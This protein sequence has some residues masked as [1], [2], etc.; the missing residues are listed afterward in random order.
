MNRLKKIF[1]T[2]KGKIAFYPSLIS[3][4]GILLA[5][6]MI[7]L[8]QKQISAYLMKVAPSLVI[9]NLDTAQILLSTLISGLISLVVFSF[10]MV[11]VLLN[12]AS[13]NFSPR[14]LPGIIS[15]QK[16]QVVLGIYIATILYMIFILVSIEP[17]GSSYQTPGFAVLI[18]IIL[19]VVCLGSFIYFIHHISQSIQVGNILT[20]IH[21]RTKN[22]IL[23]TIKEQNAVSADFNG[24]DNWTDVKINK[25]GYFNDILE[26]ELLEICKEHSTKVIV[27][28]FKGQFI[29]SG[30]NS[31]LT[32]TP[33]LPEVR[34][35]IMNTL[36][37]NNEELVGEND[38]YGF[39]QISEIG[40]K[41]MSPGI[42]DPGTALSSIDCLTSLFV[43]Y[44][45]KR[46][47]YYL[48]DDNGKNRVE[49]KNIKFSEILYNVMTSYRIYC[50]HDTLVMKKLLDMLNTLATIAP[51][52]LLREA[53]HLEIA[54]LKLVINTHIDNERDVSKI[55]TGFVSWS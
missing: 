46:E 36:L 26:N 15:N 37:F 39:R 49:I 55:E 24:R 7:Y 22:T 17:T 31:F 3:L 45:D 10:S 23:K 4:F 47:Q 18:G 25:T 1:Q 53:I 54:Q 34:E 21:E 41:A 29:V 27:H 11:M 32:E 52:S 38:V 48:T 8:E 5:F 13:S 16:H 19:T 43:S 50:K 9:N 30:T 20:S 44:M 33:V 12:Q 6:V 42:N 2:I 28:I 40:I 35:K 14:V 51:N